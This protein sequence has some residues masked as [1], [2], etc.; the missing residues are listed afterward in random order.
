MSSS[1]RLDWMLDAD[2]STA[3][4]ARAVPGP[5]SPLLPLPLPP[6][7]KCAASMSPVSP[8]RSVCARAWDTA[9]RTPLS[10]PC[11]PCIVRSIV[12]SMKKSSAPRLSSMLPPSDAP[13]SCATDP[14]LRRRGCFDAPDFGGTGATGMSSRFAA[15]D[16][17][18]V[19]SSSSCDS[20]CGETC[21]A[22]SCSAT[23][24]EA[25][26]RDTTRAGPTHYTQQ[27]TLTKKSTSMGSEARTPVPITILTRLG[28][29]R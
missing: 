14:A 20:D 27:L 25:A 12:S 19:N 2:A 28:V 24:S 23:C 7:G 18:A 6:P 17:S 9:P 22:R 8:P 10:P 4:P 3:E 21:T 16:E 29:A 15:A 5:S 26:V 13:N 1:S 11:A